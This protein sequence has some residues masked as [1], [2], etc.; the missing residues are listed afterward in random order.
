MHTH[1]TRT[2]DLWWYLVQK[3]RESLLKKLEKATE[4]AQKVE[5]QS[6]AYLCVPFRDCIGSVFL[7]LVDDNSRLAASEESVRGDWVVCE[8]E[9]RRGGENRRFWI[10]SDGFVT[11]IGLAGRSWKRKRRTQRRTWSPRRQGSRSWRKRFVEQACEHE[12]AVLLCT[13]STLTL[14]AIH[15]ARMHDVPGITPVDPQRRWA[16]GCVWMGTA[17]RQRGGGSAGAEAARAHAGASEGALW[18]P[19]RQRPHRRCAPDENGRERHPDPRH[20]L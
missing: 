9:D 5:D 20:G 3:E 15:H 18:R 1:E 2:S 7:M 17:G 4:Q 19:Q 11:W 10:R 6:A 16:E 13:Q 12:R 8:L 14:Q